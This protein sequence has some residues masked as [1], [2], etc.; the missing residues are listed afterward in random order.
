MVTSTSFAAASSLSLH[1]ADCDAWAHCGADAQFEAVCFNNYIQWK[2]VEILCRNSL[3]Y[4][5]VHSSMVLLVLKVVW[6]SPN[7]A[8]EAKQKPGLS[9]CQRASG[10]PTERSVQLGSIPLELPP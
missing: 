8:A 10:S 5:L 6:P 2:Y 7:L 1:L 4:S 9:S 3:P